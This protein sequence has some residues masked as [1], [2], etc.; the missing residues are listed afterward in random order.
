MS[1]W[2]QIAISDLQETIDPGIIAAA[3]ARTPGATLARIAGAVSTVRGAVSTGNDLDADSTRVPN[4]L[5]DLTARL[6][7]WALLDFLMM[8]LSDD[9]RESRKY[10]QSRLNRITDKKIRFE[11]PDNPGGSAEMEQSETVR[12]INPV[13]KLTSRRQ[14]SGL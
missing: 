3:E 5:K 7:A 13:R 8:E 4:S 11:L 10:D 14:L 1:N 9:Q 6:A 12:I 2:T